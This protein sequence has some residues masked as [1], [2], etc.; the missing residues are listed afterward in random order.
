MD[1]ISFCGDLEA[2]KQELKDKGYFDS[3]SGNYTHGM[4][5]TPIIVNGNSSLSLVRGDIVA[6]DNIEILGTYDEIFA[7]T[8]LD[9]KYK[10]VYPYDVAIEFTDEAG[11]VQSY[12]RPQKIGEFA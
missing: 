8:A 12:M 10:S 6:F 4:T 2:F 5:L 1:K 7:D 11:V 9:A 3:E